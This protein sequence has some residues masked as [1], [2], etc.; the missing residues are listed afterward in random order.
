MAVCMKY[1]LDTD[2]CIYTIKGSHQAIADRM[3]QLKVGD[4]A[5]SVITLHELVYGACKS[6]AIEKN[7]QLVHKMLRPLRKIMF[8]E[9]CAEISAR[10]RADL[11]R[12][13]T[14]VGL[15][16]LHIAATA[17][18][19]NLTLVSNNMREFS[20]IAGLRIENWT[21]AATTQS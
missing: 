5:V 10:I 14:P 3:S 20:R 15:M 8:D 16:D 4:C 7:L 18:V 6:Q 9:A 2:I 21:L 19:H 12:Q 13:G 17:L 11:A 1:L